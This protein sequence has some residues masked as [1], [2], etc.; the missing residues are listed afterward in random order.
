[1]SEYYNSHYIRTDASGNIVEGWSDGPHNHREVTDDDILLNDKGGYQF[2]LFPDG[3][4]NPPLY[5]GMSMIPLYRWDGEKVTRR[6]DAEIEADRAAVQEAQERQARISELHRLLESTDYA[7][8]KIAEGAASREE[9][10]DTIAQRQSWREEINALEKEPE[11]EEESGEA[12]L[13][14]SPDDR[15][16]RDN[17]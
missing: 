6:T 16:L 15:R 8:I 11:V 7:V 13:A 12:A 3:E 1:M 10:A 4:E 2:R 9:Y 17:V 5:Y 14:L